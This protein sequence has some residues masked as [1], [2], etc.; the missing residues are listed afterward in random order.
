MT[1][2]AE[3]VAAATLLTRLPVARLARSH[4]PA[5]SCVWAYPI[6]GLMVGALGAAV[7]S[8]LLA[9]GAPRAVAA[10]WAVLATVVVTGGLHEDGLADTA[11]GLGGGRTVERRLAI[12]RDSRI[13]SYGALALCFSVVLRILCLAASPHPLLAML[14]SGVLGR[15]S[16]L[17]LLLLLRPARPDGIAATLDGAPGGALIGL[18]LTTPFIPEA[19]LALF[20]VG[21]ASLVVAWLGRRHLGGYTGDLLGAAEQA[22]ECASLTALCL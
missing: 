11:D 8:V 10:A 15:A 21:M 16:I 12:M 18:V 14:A 13:G 7:L 2:W 6:V 1:R 5:A 19:P 3:L 9:F 17:P 20:V 4:P 22:G